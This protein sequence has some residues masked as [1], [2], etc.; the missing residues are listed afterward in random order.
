MSD[1]RLFRLKRLVAMR[2]IA[3][4]VARGALGEAVR[5]ARAAEQ[6]HNQAETAWGRWAA[7]ATRQPAKSSDELADQTAY[8]CALRSTVDEAERQR[9]QALEEEASRRQGVTCAQQELRK[10]EHLSDAAEE[11][12]RAEE[13]RRE[14]AHCDE[15]AARIHAGARGENGGLA[16]E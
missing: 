16:P 11:S 8:L 5:R 7:R 15:V 13:A 6:S 14:R 2:E 4:D 3:R 1:K 9:E 10:M 12:T